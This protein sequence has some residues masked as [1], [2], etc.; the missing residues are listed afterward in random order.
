MRRSIL[1]CKTTIPAL[2]RMRPITAKNTVYRGVGR[3]E[4]PAGE[5]DI[6]DDDN[7]EPEL[8]ISD[9][10]PEVI[11]FRHVPLCMNVPPRHALTAPSIVE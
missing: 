7:A 5:T 1:R 4:K 2:N 11:E 10:F 3:G 6:R 9:L 8:E